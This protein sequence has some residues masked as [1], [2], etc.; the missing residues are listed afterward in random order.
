MWI[1]NTEN[2]KDAMLTFAT[3]SFAAIT[4]NILLGNFQ[5]ISFGETVFTFSFIDPT[6]MGVYLA[7]TFSAYVGRKLTD[8][9][10]TSR[11]KEIEVS[12][13]KVKAETDSLKKQFED[14]KNGMV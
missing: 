8:K 9:H 11:N 13:M 6:T 12:E 5:S 3:I 10:Y 7:A 2:K 4:L 14:R 1:K